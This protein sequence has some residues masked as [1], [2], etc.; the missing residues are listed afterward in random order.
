MENLPESGTENQGVTVNQSMTCQDTKSECCRETDTITADTLDNFN[1]A[2]NSWHQLSKG[3]TVVGSVLSGNGWRNVD[4]TG[5]LGTAI[6]GQWRKPCA[7]QERIGSV[8]LITIPSAGSTNVSHTDT[9]ASLAIESRN[10]NNTY[11]SVL[12]HTTAK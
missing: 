8:A 11:S 12:K 5:N 1:G 6:T 3:F 10:L 7:D 4:Q 2:I 9:T